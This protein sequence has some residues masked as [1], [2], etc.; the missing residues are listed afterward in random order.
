LDIEHLIVVVVDELQV[1]V[2]N[3]ILGGG[4]LLNPTGGYDNM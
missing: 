1:V 2:Q 4:I 3:I